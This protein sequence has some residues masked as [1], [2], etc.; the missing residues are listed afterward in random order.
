LGTFN[1]GVAFSVK[2]FLKGFQ[3]TSLFIASSRL[4]DQQG[5]LGLNP[6]WGTFKCGVE[7]FL[8][9]RTRA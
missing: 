2:R 6:V 4:A 9:L 7:N 3:I 1:L 5:E 8:Y